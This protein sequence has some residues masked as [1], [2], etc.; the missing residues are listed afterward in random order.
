MVRISKENWLV[1]EVRHLLFGGGRRK[2]PLNSDS[3]YQK[4]GTNALW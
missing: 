1:D 3:P 4:S 2:N